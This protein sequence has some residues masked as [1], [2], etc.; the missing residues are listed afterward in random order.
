MKRYK[1]IK[2]Y[3]GSPSIGA[4]IERKK[5]TNMYFY[6]SK[7][8]CHPKKYPEF[9]K[10]I[11]ERDFEILQI[12]N[13]H[14]NFYSLFENEE[15][16]RYE[17]ENHTIYSIKRL[18]DGEIFTIGDKIS[19]W[20]NFTFEIDSIYY[21]E[22]DQLSFKL[23]GINAPVTGVFSQKTSKV[24][25]PLFISEEGVMC[26]DDSYKLFS[27]LPRGSWQKRRIFPSEAK[28]YCSWKHFHTEEAREMFILNNKRVLSLMDICGIREINNIAWTRLTELVKSRS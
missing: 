11:V 15:L 24:K 8:I 5:D 13:S 6:N 19:N 21:N 25:E 16:S 20:I 1:L 27:V 4:V 10:E 28:N 23:N 3:P 2:E 7:Q 26:L 12:K 18:S 22:Y 9:W 17:K 14:G